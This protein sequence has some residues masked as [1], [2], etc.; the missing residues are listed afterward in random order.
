MSDHYLQSAWCRDERDWWVQKQGELGLSPRTAIALARIWPTSAPWPAPFVDE[1]GHP[2]VGFCFYDK[3]RA[4][5]P[6]QPYEWPAPDGTSKGPFRDQLLD[7]VGWLWQKIE[8]LKKRAHERRAAAADAAKLAEES[9]QALYLHAR[10]EHEPTWQAARAALEN[11]GF[12]VFPVDKPDAVS[13]DPAQAK[14]DQAARIDLLGRCDA[15]LLVGTGNARAVNE[16]LIVVGRGDRQ[17]ARPKYS[18]LRAVRPGRH[19]RGADRHRGTA[20]HGAALQVDWIDGTRA[21]WPVDVKAWLT[22]KSAA[23]GG[24]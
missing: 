8:L 16:D 12:A 20:A 21:P 2:F 4:D 10:Q 19:G 22:Q 17:L 7:L 9:G 15:L 14:Q 5:M 3:A 11:Q 18:T 1:R 24:R 23:A 13:A 6:P